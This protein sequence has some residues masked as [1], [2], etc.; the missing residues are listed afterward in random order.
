MTIVTSRVEEKITVLGVLEDRKKA[1]V[2]AFFKSIPKQLSKTITSVSSDLYEGFIN[3]AKE[4]LV[5][6]KPSNTKNY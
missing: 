5:P 4:V 3:A 6:L 2:L 1:T